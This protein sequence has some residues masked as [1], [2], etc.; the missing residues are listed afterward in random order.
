MK[1]QA[2]FV[3]QPTY[4][5]EIEHRK[6][7]SDLPIAAS[8]AGK[9]ASELAARGYVLGLQDLLKGGEKADIEKNLDE[10]VGARP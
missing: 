2:L 1:P 10:V 5:A 6:N 9:L 4:A 7:W 3:A 8:E